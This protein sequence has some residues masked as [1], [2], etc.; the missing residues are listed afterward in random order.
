MKSARCLSLVARGIKNLG[1]HGRATGPVLF[2]R[3][4]ATY[5]PASRSDT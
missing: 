3:T 2:S 1:E 5:R 4:V